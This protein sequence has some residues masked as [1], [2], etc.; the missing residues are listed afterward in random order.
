MYSVGDLIFYGRTGVCRVEEIVAEGRGEET[1]AYYSLRPLYQKCCIRTPVSG[2][3]VCS[4]PIISS[5]EAQTLIRR[6][7]ELEAEP[8]HN[9]NLNQLRDYYRARLEEFNCESLIRL[10]KSLYLKKQ[11][12]IARRRKFGA[13][14]ERFLHEAEDLLFGELAAALEIDRDQVETYIASCLKTE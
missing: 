10:T 1:R 4:R 14:D 13:V 3:K 7:P 9:S 12:A 6:M 8:Y 2:G 5:Q 11:E